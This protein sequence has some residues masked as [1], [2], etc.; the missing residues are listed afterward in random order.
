MDRGSAYGRATAAEKNGGDGH[1][2]SRGCGGTGGDRAA[3]QQNEEGTSQE[4]FPG[5]AEGIGGA[6]AG[7]GSSVS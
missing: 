7:E 2:Y 4:R 5:E 1:S 6:R 3:A